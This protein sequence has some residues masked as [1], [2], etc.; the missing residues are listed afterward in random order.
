MDKSTTPHI[1]SQNTLTQPEVRGKDLG[2]EARVWKEIA[3]CEA[4]IA[5]MRN[6][7][8]HQLGFA[9]LEEFGLEFNNK[10]KSLK[11]KTLCT[12][13]NMQIMNISIT[14]Y[15]RYVLITIIVT[16]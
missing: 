6:M 12:A 2:E 4:R 16:K 9:D 8:K 1:S 13:I 11:F 15:V 3:S 14:I 10:L 5:L 7:I